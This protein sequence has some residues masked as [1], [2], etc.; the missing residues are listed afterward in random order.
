MKLK[1]G[2]NDIIVLIQLASRTRRT[3]QTVPLT[4]H[5]TKG[6]RRANERPLGPR[7]TADALERAEL[8]RPTIPE[9]EQVALIH[10]PALPRVVRHG[11]PLQTIVGRYRPRRRLI[12]PRSGQTTRMSSRAPA[13]LLA[14]LE[15][16]EAAQSF[17]RGERQGRLR[18][19]FFV[20]QP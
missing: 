17:R 9:R 4:H 3:S 16:V 6:S 2:L 12:A 15:V 1:K 13:A 10:D 18:A 11:A 14:P 20:A 8:F 7:D 5:R 19:A